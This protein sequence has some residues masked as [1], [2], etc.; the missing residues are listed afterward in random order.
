MKELW[1]LLL[2]AQHNVSGVP[3]KFLD[4]KEEEAKKKKVSLVL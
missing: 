2:S 1:C 4:E 3:Q